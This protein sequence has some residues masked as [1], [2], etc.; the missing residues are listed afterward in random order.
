M[1][2][3]YENEY[4]LIYNLYFFYMHDFCV[5]CGGCFRHKVGACVAI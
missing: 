5:I 1:K 3:V 2:I 4:V